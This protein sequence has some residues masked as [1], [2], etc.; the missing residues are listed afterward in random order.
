MK[1]HSPIF[2]MIK[3][4]IVYVTLFLFPIIFLP[5][6]Q[7][8]YITTKLYFL[9]IAALALLGVSLIEFIMTKKVVWEKRPF[10]NNA[11][12]LIAA[13]GLS[14]LISS[15]DKILGLLNLNFGLIGIFSLSVLYY[16]L[17]RHHAVA[18]HHDNDT[19]G[20]LNYFTVLTAS[21]VLVALI[22]IVMFFQPFKNVALPPFLQF[23]ANASF[24]TLGGQVDLAIFL[25]FMALAQSISIMSKQEGR[26]SEEATQSMWMSVISICVLLI[27]VIFTLFSI[28]KP[29][30]GGQLNLATTMPPFRI[31]WYGAVETLK[32]PLSALFG[33]GVSQFSTMFTAVK[34]AQYNNSPLWQIQ[35]FGVSRSTLLHVMTETGV[36]GLIAMILLL[37]QAIRVAGK[38]TNLMNKALLG[39]MILIIALFPPSLPIF[40]LLFVTLA[41]IAQSW[42][43]AGAGEH[44]EVKAVAYDMASLPP[45]YAGV[46]L[47]AIAFLGA[48]GYF[49]GRAYASEFYFKKSLDAIVN[50][51]AR[52][53]YD[54]QRQAVILNPYNDKFRVS[55][56]QTNLL[57][58]NTIAQNAT[59]PGQDGQPRQIS[60]IDRQNITQAIQASIN[61]SKAAVALNPQNASHWENL[62][63]VYRN[64]INVVQ[65]ADGWAVASYQEAIRLDPQNPNLRLNLG[66]IYYSLGAYEDA[67]KM[68]E[69]AAVL[70]PDW[71][72]ARYNLGWASA[73]KGDFTRAAQEMQLVVGMLDP[74]KDQADLKK[75]Q[76]DLQTFIAKIPKAQQP[77]EE[78]NPPQP[79][80]L[81]LP[82]PP[83]AT[84]DPKLE[85]DKKEAEP[86]AAPVIPRE[87]VSPS[88]EATGSATPTP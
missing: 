58:A 80:Q 38:R 45:L 33:V 28:F 11:L 32:H 56:A 75:A 88:P 25:G 35:S 29:T 42:A 54:N 60:D 36:F 17:S 51:N 84:V 14:V 30:A 10:D 65:G 23:L 24:T 22:S 52:D 21:T 27:A 85:L 59:Q 31:S 26:D 5:L 4:G 67:A 47:L 53:L 55:F 63:G 6:T 79:Q 57:I 68:F 49:L 34:D 46:I 72:N 69:Q 66:G 81:S 78:A 61:E 12:L 3:T 83:V 87:Q 15:P 20:Y 71:S 39:Y 64:I 41:A 8:F 37:V 62:A 76:A 70:K 86:P 2:S 74:I 73:Q 1:S 48:T 18:K 44:A 50:N 77:T 13:V 9:G 7:E 82:T 43:K 16:Y 40:F 19:L